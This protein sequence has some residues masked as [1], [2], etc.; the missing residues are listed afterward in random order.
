MVG[1][2][3]RLMLDK[4]HCGYNFIASFRGVY[5]YRLVIAD[6]FWWEE[7]KW[8]FYPLAMKTLLWP[9]VAFVTI[10]ITN[11]E[12]RMGPQDQRAFQ[13]AEESGFATLY[14]VILKAYFT[15]ELKAWTWFLGASDS[16]LGFNKLFSRAQN[17][18]LLMHVRLLVE[19]GE[20]GELDHPSSSQLPIVW[21][22][23]KHSQ[24]DI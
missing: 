5:E 24:S 21:E 8:R 10:L 16:I 14:H 12:P 13:T 3:E 2:S 9:R 19:D 22:S 17:M 4:Q 15:L 20:L 1:P 23:V 7:A 11:C 18:Y 6:L